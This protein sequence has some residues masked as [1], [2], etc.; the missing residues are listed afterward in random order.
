MASRAATTEPVSTPPAHD[1]PVDT[2]DRLFTIGEL[3]TVH[4]ITTRT[5]RFYESKG[6]IRPARK[7][8]ARIQGVIGPG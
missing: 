8:V 4:G 2:P 7:G 6:L 5:I 1:E 3:A